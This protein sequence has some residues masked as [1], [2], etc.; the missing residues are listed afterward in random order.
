MKIEVAVY[1][2]LCQLFTLTRQGLGLA[3]TKSASSAAS[4]A[5]S[6]SNAGSLRALVFRP[7]RRVFRVFLVEVGD[8]EDFWMRRVAR[9]SRKVW[10]LALSSVFISSFC[11]DEM[12]AQR[13]MEKELRVCYIEHQCCTRGD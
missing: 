3:S 11:C 9:Q 13:F 2:L 1:C 12:K 10:K 4:F 5:S 8:G 6:S 7:T